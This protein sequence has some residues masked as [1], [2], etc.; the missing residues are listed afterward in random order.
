MSDELEYLPTL[1]A[2]IRAELDAAA[3]SLLAVA[4]TDDRI[5]AERIARLAAAWRDVASDLAGATSPPKAWLREAIEAVER[6]LD[7]AAEI[8]DPLAGALLLRSSP[9]LAVSA[10]PEPAEIRRTEDT[11]RGIVAGALADGSLAPYPPRVVTV[12]VPGAERHPVR[13]AV[14]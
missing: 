10:P 11:A 5:L 8:I 4:A 13:V 14:P 12:V 3:E 9:L 2:T 1:R 6:S 7:A